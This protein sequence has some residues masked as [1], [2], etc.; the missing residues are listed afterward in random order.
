MSTQSSL[1][2]M[3]VFDLVFVLC[4]VAFNWLIIG[5][6]IA[7]KK[8]HPKLRAIFGATFVSLGI[9]FTTVFIH[10]LVEGR[11]LLTMVRFGFVLLYIAVELLLDYILKFDF[12]QK[13]ISHV[14]Y[15]LLEYIALFSL[16]GIS[17]SIDRTW[18]WIISI[19]FWAVLG[20]LIYLYWGK[21]K[22]RA[23]T[24]R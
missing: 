14:P 22:Q 2:S 19:S 15:I 6:F 11:D 4:A 17:F 16:I 1:V 12:R 20:S 18:G 23:H 13:P 8:V 24:V 9:P 5:V 3:D 7:T 10:Y 21:S